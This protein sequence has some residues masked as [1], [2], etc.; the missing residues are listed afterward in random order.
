MPKINVV[1]SS[2]DQKYSADHDP[3]ADAPKSPAYLQH[4]AYI[5]TTGTQ[6]TATATV[7]VDVESMLNI[8][9]VNFQRF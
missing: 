5:E 1:S 7:V 8:D 6:A 3:E 4:V 9:V 2:A